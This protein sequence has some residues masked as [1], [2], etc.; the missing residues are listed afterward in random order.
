M[1]KTRTRIGSILLALALVLT[2][3]PAT[4]LADE[5]TGVSYRDENGDTATCGSAT[6]VDADTSEWAS[7][8]DS[9]AWYVVNT[10]VTISTRITVSGDVHL[11]L[12]D[13]GKLTAEKGISVT[14]GNSLTIYGQGTED[15]EL[16][17][18]S[19]QY[20]ENAGIGGDSEDAAHGNITINGGKI[21]ATGGADAAGIGSGYEHKHTSD[22]SN[23]TITI[24]GGTVT[25]TGSSNGAGIGGGHANDIPGGDIVIK[26][27]TVI[28]N[29]GTKAAGI[30]TGFS[31]YSLNGRSITISGG[32]VTA[33]GGIDSKGVSGGAGIGAGSSCAGT[34]LTEIIIEGDADVTANGGDQAAGIGSGYAAKMTTSINIGGEAVVKATGGTG[35]YGGAGI[36]TG[37][38]SGSTIGDI[39]IDGGDVTATGGTTNENGYSGAGIGGGGYSKSGGLEGGV[40]IPPSSATGQLTISAGTVTAT[41]GTGADGI[42]DGTGGMSGDFSTGENGQ[43]VIYTSSISDDDVTDDWS[44]IIFQGEAGTVYGDVT[45]EENLEI[46]SGETLEVPE[47]SQLTV[48]EGATLTNN[49][50]ITNEG[51]IL[52]YGELDGEENVEGT[53]PVNN[54]VASY[55]DSEESTVLAET[56]Q[57][58]VTK[59]ANNTTVELLQTYDASGEDTLTIDDGRKITLDLGGHTLTLSRFDLERGQ[60]TVQNGDVECSGQAFNV[61]AAPKNDESTDYYTKLTLAK[62]ATINADFAICLFPEPNSNHGANSAIEVCGEIK[63]G[64]IFVSGNLGNDTD[65]AAAIV[66]SGKVPTITIYEGAVVNNGTEGQG[67]AMNGLAY[68]TVDGGT[69]TGSE[70]IGVKRGKLTVNGGTFIS[71]GE[72]VDPVV[73]NNNGTENTG[74]TISIT[75]TY[76][77][78]GTIDVTIKDGTFTSQK[79]SAVYLGHSKKTNDEYNAYENGVSLNISGGTFSSA[80]VGPVYIAD[81]IEGDR[82]YSK[83]VITGGTFSSDPSAYVA[84]GYRA[85]QRG[86]QWIV[87]KLDNLAVAE[88]NGVKYTTLGEAV[89]AVHELTGE[90]RMAGTTIKLLKNA[91]GGG[92]GV[93]YK[94][95]EN[96][97]TKDNYPANITIDLGGH[98]YTVTEP[99]VGSSGTETN[100]FQFLKGSKV[101]IKNGTITNTEGK[102]LIQN[103]SDLTLEDVDVS[104]TLSSYVISNNC[105]TVNV[106]GSTNITAG[107]GKTAF[108]I[109]FWPTSYPD[110]TQIVLDTTGTITGSFEMGLYGNGSTKLEGPCKSTL[111]IKNVKHVGQF[112][113]TNGIRDFE[114]LLTD[115]EAAEF[116]ETM[117]VIT[118]GTF[119]S[120]PSD[121][122]A[123][124]YQAYESGEQWIVGKAVQSVTVEPASVTLKLDKPTTTLS[125]TVLPEDAHQNTVTWSSSDEDVATV[126]Q[127]GNV[128]AVAPGTATITATAGDKFDTC[129]VTVTY[130]DVTSITLDQTEVTLAAG[131]TTELK[132]IVLPDSAD[133]T[134]TWTSSDDKIASVNNGKITGINE[135]TAIIT[136]AAADGQ[137]ATCEVTVTAEGDVIVNVAEPD[138]TVKISGLTSDQETAVETTAKSVNADAAIAAAAKEVSDGLDVDALTAQARED[139]DAG[140]DDPIYLFTQAYLEIT[141]TGAEIDENGKIASITLDIKPMVRV[142]ASTAGSIKD[143]DENNS[144]EVQKPQELTI[145]GDANIR[146]TL[147][148][149]LTGAT[150]LYIKHEKDAAHTYYYK[151]TVSGGELAFLNPH[152]FSAFTFPADSE[153]VATIDDRGY[154]SLQAAVDAASNRDTITLNQTSNEKITVQRSV[155]F[156]LDKNGKDFTGTISAGAGYEITEAKQDDGTVVYT[157]TRISTGSGSS[158]VSGDYIISVN[159]TA[160]GKVTV[161]PGR[162]DKGDEVTITAIPNDGYVL[163]SLTVTDKDGD[164]VRVSSEG[165]DKYT[166]TMPGSTVTVKAVF[167]PEG[168]AVVTPEISFTDVAES[169]WAYNEIQ[170]AAENG[171]MTGTTATT[172]NPNGTVT[173][174][175]VWMI[176]ARMSGARPADMAAAKAWAVNNGISDGTN[177]GGAVTRQQ[178]VALLYRFAGQYG[179][180]VSAKADLSGYPD[181]ASLASYA[182]DAMAWSVANG[183]IGGTTAGTLNPAGTANRA[184]FAAI[185][186]RFYQT[187]AV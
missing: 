109:S 161:N 179:Y 123:D 185:L 54:P 182:A 8:L 14:S 44:G 141:A 85:V 153:V 167:A 143:L 140:V 78:A 99:T 172:F 3:L 28:A 163:Q 58:A 162:A 10:N 122:V 1:K 177:P 81:T 20:R 183:I 128:N 118:G 133:Q 61:Y 40:F 86:Q 116:F 135:G 148:D 5:A 70:A 6:V 77:Y 112:K 175:Q 134:V 157:V 80:N 176:L 124:G 75:S 84:D 41:G 154:T 62:D 69:I 83:Q 151:G 60:L 37:G 9:E 53:Q 110:G 158:D 164:T 42:G 74:A 93:G 120:D 19:Q 48:A 186:W 100:G 45:L 22:T 115:D 168:S 2:L 23:G 187:T 117:C 36:G 89:A 149:D 67:I 56:L 50:Q 30:G 104:S 184:Q 166:F 170:W 16:I 105:G 146:L 150:S 129:S 7:E 96:N 114:T 46:Q 178:L 97:A 156:T 95:I 139:L 147:P 126:D 94:T 121:Y 25:A 47:G 65:S 98:T 90:D 171:Y 49:G 145:S 159:K 52:V 136:A 130:A 155:T 32:N 31:N 160:G 181:V 144:V 73:A 101:T 21:T 51:E 108:D 152:G 39:T 169:F 103:Y 132:T 102:I 68:V 72:Y 76:N 131:G 180:D 35:Y 17:A 55:T 107:S 106:L 13:G 15:G 87:D 125:V 137:T 59:A 29:G 91:S 79:A 34:S 138:V 33:T 165:R 142:L 64:G 63:K 4:A 43:A 24:N 113:T 57:E 82:A 27:G 88:I 111:T 71:N 26:D 11:I 66:A 92:I 18:T 12:A 38:A 119:S 127:N 174:Q 173:R